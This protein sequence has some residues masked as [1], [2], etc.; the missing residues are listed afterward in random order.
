VYSD[1]DDS[2]VL[3]DTKPPVVVTFGQNEG[4][5]VP[6]DGGEELHE[7]LVQNGYDRVVH[8]R[9]GV[10]PDGEY[11]RPILFYI[12]EDPNKS[13]DSPP[14]DPSP[15]PMTAANA[16]STVDPGPD[17]TVSAVHDATGSVPHSA[18]VSVPHSATVSTV[19]GWTVSEPAPRAAAARRTLRRS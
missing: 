3:N 13:T 5:K 9:Y 14:L 16:T 18:T 10:D 12:R 19:H 6:K 11:T 17:A 8:Q 4:A 1:T 2:R 15:G 7:W